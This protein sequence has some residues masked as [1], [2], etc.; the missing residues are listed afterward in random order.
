MRKILLFLTTALVL[1]GC[2]SILNGRYQKVTIKTDPKNEVFINGEKAKVVNDK[3]LLKRDGIPKDITV[4][5]QG[6]KDEH[7]AVIQYKQSRLYLLSWVPFGILIIPPAFDNLEK[8]HNYDNEIKI[9]EI[10]IT[11]PQR[12]IK[13]KDIVLNE[14]VAD[15]KNDSVNYRYFTSYKTFIKTDKKEKGIKSNG[16]NVKFENARFPDLLNELLKTKGYIDTTN[17][18][19]KKNYSG[20]FSVDATI[21]AY[22]HHLIDTDI[23]DIYGGMIYVDL[24]INWQIFNSYKKPVYSSKTKSK[25]GLFSI[26]K[27]D[28]DYKVANLAIKDAIEIGFI[29]FMNLKDVD[30]ILKDK[31][32]QSL[33][34]SFEE[35][36]IPKT[37]KYASTLSEAV[38]SSVTIKNKN[39]HGSGFFISNN[40]YVITNYHVVA[41]TSD[42]KVVM[43]DE[44]IQDVK[45][46]R[47]SKLHDLALLK[48]DASGVIPLKI[49]ESEIE[50][51]TEIYAIGTPLAED[52]AQT[53]SKGIISAIRKTSETSKLIQ[54]DASV[55]AGN[56]GGAIVN[57][58]GL[59]I[60][61]VSSKMKSFGIEGLAFGIPGYE[62]LNYLKINIR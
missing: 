17:K 58:S 13:A 15:L 43:N 20:N 24:T 7:M 52:L 26:I 30:A 34:E 61:V 12:D 56:S 3:Y 19:L 38:K 18:I 5:Q 9:G 11:I 59:L 47:F 57:K 62:I 16:N 31:S 14:F 23:S 51:A 21:T 1:S 37:D 54:T 45:I 39:G 42:L 27:G 46:I 33:E 10:M 35:L 4:K 29:E 2:A 6:F 50:V 48:I 36:Y 53:I 8:S 41:D 25:S 22:S 55:N 44:S 32:Q 28:R 60:G 49:N 40:G